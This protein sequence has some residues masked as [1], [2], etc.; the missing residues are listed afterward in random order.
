M[1]ESS[2]MGKW[3]A[4]QSGNVKGRPKKKEPK[5]L[6]SPADLHDIVMSVA[7]RQTTVTIEGR[8]ETVSVYE[9]NTIGMATGSGPARLARKAFVDLVHSAAA[10]IE[11]AR[12]NRR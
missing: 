9:A 1:P 12:K 2:S 3:P 5:H 10:R 8:Q 6:S 11:Y 4:G 7:N